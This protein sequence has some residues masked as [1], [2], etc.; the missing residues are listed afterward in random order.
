MLLVHKI[1]KK[2]PDKVH[3][4][5]SKEAIVSTEPMLTWK[6]F[7]NQ[8]I[9]WAS[10]AK[11]YDD[12]RIMGVLLLVYLFNLSFLVLL[13][14][15]SW[16]PYY[17]ISLFSLW[18]AKTIIELPFVYSVATFFNKQSLIKY[19]FFFQPLHIIYTIVSGL[20]GQFG[21]YEWKGRSV[22]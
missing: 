19:F 7:F 5:K 12:K 22:R 14:A 9:R 2:F 15:A 17:F 4:L 18:I 16:Y 1:W 10:K 20:F 13:I 8:R 3:Y 11:N 6:S 21:K